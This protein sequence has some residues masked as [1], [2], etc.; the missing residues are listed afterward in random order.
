MGPQSNGLR[1]D[2]VSPY[3][4][5]S[6]CQT[7]FQCKHFSFGHQDAVSTIV[8]GVNCDFLTGGGKDGTV[9]LWKTAD[10][11]QLVF[12]LPKGSSVE[13]LDKVNAEIF[14]SVSDNG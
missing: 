10:E 5:H 12:N 8:A 4:L 2:S 3:S 6:S 13:A 9:R 11:V 14:A 7:S 1:G